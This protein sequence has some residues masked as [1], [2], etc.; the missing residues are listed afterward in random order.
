[1]RILVTGHKG[2]LGSDL[3]EAL[4]RG[5]DVN[6]IDR[7]EF[8]IASAGDCLRVV[9]EF[10]PDVIVN[11]AAYTDVD[12]CEAN[13]DD[14]FA[15]NAEGVRNIASAC[16][17][18]RTKIVHYSTDYVFDG[19]KGEPYLEDDP[20]RPINLYGESKRRGEESLIET[21]EDHVLIRTAWLYGRHGKNFVKAIL[22]KAKADGQLRVVDDQV[23]SPTYSLD[24]AQAT[25][26]LIELDSRGIYHVTNRGVCS[27]YQF[28]QRIVEYAQLPGVTVEPIKSHEIDR[29]AKRPA[30]S[31]LSNRKFMDATRKAMRP[32]QVALNEYLTGQSHIHR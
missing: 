16:K 25:K 4:G 11:A 23:G 13:R 19:T 10:A 27:W 22:A 12:G 29:K 5:H 31:V 3:M 18:R 24:L 7:D 20:C 14:C 6:G 28:A 21:A 1:M 2:M 17:G 8:D 26:L 30:Y 32:W 15:V 9:D